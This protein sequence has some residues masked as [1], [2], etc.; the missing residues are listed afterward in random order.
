MSGQQDTNVLSSNLLRKLHHCVEAKLGRRISQAAMAT[1]LGIST[2]TYLEYLRGTNSPL[3]MR[4]LLDL[5][6]MLDDDTLAE[7]IAVWRT[8]RTV[9]TRSTL[10]I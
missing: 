1:E 3:G 9:E 7:L 6:S 4:V 8:Q 5:L 10:E 2:R